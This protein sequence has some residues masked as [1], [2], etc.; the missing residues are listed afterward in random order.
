MAI[1]MP[2]FGSAAVTEQRRTARV[3]PVTDLLSDLLLEQASIAG[4]SAARR[5]T[6]PLGKWRQSQ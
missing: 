3:L 1:V 6:S 2:H 4:V 5:V